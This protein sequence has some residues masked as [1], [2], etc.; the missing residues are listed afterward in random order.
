MNNTFANSVFL[1]RSV[2]ANRGD[3]ANQMGIVAGLKNISKISKIYVS[4]FYPHHFKGLQ[5]VQTVQPPALRGYLTT[6]NE[7]K[8]LAHRPVIFW[9]GGVDLQDTGS[10]L[11]MLFVNTRFKLLK[12]HGSK[13]ILAFQGAGPVR[14]KAGLKLLKCIVNKIDGAI[15]REPTALKLLLS[16]GLEKTR[17]DI[18]V[19]SAVLLE[20]P[21]IFFGQQYFSSHGFNL[22]EPIIGLNL[23]RWFHQKGGW[24]PTG[25]FQKKQRVL[26]GK[27]LSL[28]KNVATVLNRMYDDGIRQIAFLPMYRREPE[29]WEDDIFLLE[30]VQYRLNKPFRT[31]LV[32]EDLNVYNYL[33]IFSQLD[34]MI[35]TRLHS[36]ILAHVAG[37]PSIH[38]CYEHKGKEF[39]NISKRENMVIDIEDCCDV[40]GYDLI[41]NRIDNIISNMELHKKDVKNKI[42]ELKKL[43]QESLNKMLVQIME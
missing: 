28:V 16:A 1:A 23:R 38:I 33:S 7:E 19:D 12:R 25:M 41:Y 37:V 21:D 34:V 4:T 9:G 39:F 15:V 18:A 43:A 22:K 3:F 36:T 17:I 11:K 20:M 31:I 29:F 40:A 32:D 26:E 13:L 6:W 5:K 24:I 30:N 14:S 27:M 2:R 35:G 42:N 8:I 10:K